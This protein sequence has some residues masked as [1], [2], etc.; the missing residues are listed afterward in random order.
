MEQETETRRTYAADVTL[1]ETEFRV[2]AT[3]IDAKGFAFQRVTPQ[4]FVDGR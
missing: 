3:G 4:L 1:P 2:L